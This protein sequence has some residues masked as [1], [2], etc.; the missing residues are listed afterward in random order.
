VSNHRESEPEARRPG[1]RRQGLTRANLEFEWTDW[2]ANLSYRLGIWV[3]VLPEEL[4]HP[5]AGTAAGRAMVAGRRHRDGT[6]PTTDH[7]THR[8]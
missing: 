6:R 3:P 7:I 8:L 2:R 4:H 1:R 5:A